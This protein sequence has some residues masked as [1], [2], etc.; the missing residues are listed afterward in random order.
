MSRALSGCGD[1]GLTGLQADTRFVRNGASSQM[2]VFSLELPSCATARQLEPA[3]LRLETGTGRV[4]VLAAVLRPRGTPCHKN[5]FAATRN[6][7]GFLKH[8]DFR[9]GGRMTRHSREFL[10]EATLQDTVRAATCPYTS[11][12]PTECAPPRAS[13]A[14]HRASG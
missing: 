6:R 9:R 13:P 8:R 5:A 12:G 1:C 11:V 4:R 10:G 7:P 14:M 3:R 2:E